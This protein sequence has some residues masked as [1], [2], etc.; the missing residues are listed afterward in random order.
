M[1]FTHINELGFPTM[2]DVS[3]KEISDRQASAKAVITMK[4]E[5]LDKIFNGKVKKGEVISTAKI[6]GIIA[7]KRTSDLIPLCHQVPL[8]S[9]QIEF[10]QIALDKLMI[11]SYVQ[12]KYITGVEMEALVAASTAAL[13]I[14]DMCKAVDRCMKIDELYLD[15]KSGGRSGNLVR[16]SIKRIYLK[17]QKG[18]NILHMS[19]CNLDENGIEGFT[20]GNKAISLLDINA[21]VCIEN[22]NVEQLCWKKFYANFITEGFDYSNLKVGDKFNIGDT[23]IEI[24]QVGKP[25]FDGCGIIVNGKSCVLKNNC[26][27]AKV[28]KPGIVKIGSLIE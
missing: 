24:T 22:E 12:C 15:Q 19:D 11:I 16:S 25:C 10:S 1:G 5:T 20:S 6:A 13:T 28:V 4:P 21:C 27:F 14:Y 17:F 7:A 8:T 26:A 9:V 3:K 18:G 23:C 2:V